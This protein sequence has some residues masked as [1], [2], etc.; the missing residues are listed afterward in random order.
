[1]VA[2]YKRETNHVI[3]PLEVNIYGEPI[4]RAQKVKYNGI[5]VDKNLTWNEQY[6]NLKSKNKSA[7]SSLRILK[8]IL[9]QSKLDQM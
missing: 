3:D 1:M 8:N 9:P 5:T 2:C 4:K 6:K 7:L